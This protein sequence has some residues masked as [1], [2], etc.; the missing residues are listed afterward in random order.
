MTEQ[1]NIDAV[2]ARILRALQR[3]SSRPI[4]ELAAAV[5]LSPSACHRRVKLLEKA[6]MIT[7]YVARLDRRALGMDV[8][9]FVEIT[10]DEQTEEK[11]DAFEASVV[12]CDAIV[13]CVKISGGSDYLLR[14]VSRDLDH[15]EQIHR[16]RIAQLPGVSRIEA[17]FVLRTVQGWQGYPVPQAAE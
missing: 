16:R 1:S 12:K 7:G 17:R 13:E 15:F 11:M 5:G 8:E 4:A 6:E 10:L 3:D 2:D 9:V 14:L